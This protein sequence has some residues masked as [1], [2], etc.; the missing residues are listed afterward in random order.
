[1]RAQPWVVAASCLVSCLALGQQTITDGTFNNTDWTVTTISANAFS[2]TAT[3]SQAPSG[4]NPGFYRTESHGGDASNITTP[5]P[6]RFFHAYGVQTLNLTNGIASINYG[7]DLFEPSGSGPVTPVE[8]RL[9]LKQGNNIYVGPA[10]SAAVGQNPWNSFFRTGITATG[11]CLVAASTGA[12]DCNSHPNFAAGAASIQVGYQVANTIPAF[13]R[14]FLTSGIDNF[15]ITAISNAPLNCTAT[16]TPRTIRL[17]GITELAGDVILICTGGAPTASSPIPQVNIFLTTNANV[18]ITTAAIGSTLQPNQRIGSLLLLDELPPQINGPGSQ[19]FP[20]D[21]ASGVCIGYGNGSGAN[22]YGSGAQSAAAPNNRTIHA[23]FASGP[24]SI[25]WQFPLDAPAA[26][27]QRIIRLTN[28]RVDTRALQP[29]SNITATITIVPLVGNQNPLTVNVTGQPI[30]ATT[31]APLATTLRDA[32]N[33]TN[34]AAGNGVLFPLAQLNSFQRAGTFRYGEGFAT[35]F[36]AR[37]ATPAVDVNTSPIPVAQSDLTKPPAPSE[38]G[39]Y[40]PSFINP[41]TVGSYSA[42]GLATQGTRLVARFS[43]LQP[44]TSIYVDLTNIGANVNGDAARLTANETGPFSAVAGGGSGVPANVAQLAVSDTGTATA[45]WEVLAADPNATTNF[46]F[47]FYYSSTAIPLPQNSYPAPQVDLAIAPADSTSIPRFS[48]VASPRTLFSFVNPMVCSAA[49]NP[50]TLRQNGAAEL[51]SDIVLTCTGGTPTAPGG[52]IPQTTF[53]LTSTA[54]ITTP[55]NTGFVTPASN[56]WAPAGAWAILD[57]P[58]ANSEFPCLLRFSCL[59]FGNGTGQGYY[60]NGAQ[61]SETPNVRNFYP[62]SYP[63]LQSTTVQAPTRSIVWESVPVDGIG[64]GLRVFRFTGVR[65]STLNADSSAILGTITSTSANIPVVITNGA[66]LALG[67]ISNFVATSLRTADNS[68][69]LPAQGATVP[70]IPL[71]AFQQISVLRFRKLYATGFLPRIVGAPVSLDA[72]P[73]V[74]L[75]SQ[76]TVGTVF[77]SETGFWNPAFPNN[78]TNGLGNGGLAGLADQGTR[79]VARFANLPPGLLLYVD[80]YNGGAAI[81]GRAARL[82]PVEAGPFAAAP[83]TTGLPQSNVAQITVNTDGTATAVWEVLSADTL[84]A[85]S[86][87]DFGVYAATGAALGG[88]LPPNPTVRLSVGPNSTDQLPSPVYM[89]RF[90]V[91]S[92]ASNLITFTNPPPVVPTPPP[93]PALIVNPTQLSFTAIAGAPSP[94]AQALSLTSSFAGVSFNFST[95]SGGQLPITVT[96]GNGV[97]PGSATVSVN[98]VGLAPGTYRDVVTIN[99]GGTSNGSVAVGIIVTVRSAPVITSLDPRSTPAGSGPINLSVIGR[100]FLPGASVNF[101]DASLTP[102]FITGGQLNVSVPSNLLTQARVVPVTVTNPDGAVSN[103]ADFVVS[104]FQIL[105]L[106]PDRRTATAQGFNLTVTGNGFLPGA[107]VRF[108]DNPLTPASGPGFDTTSLTVSVPASAIATA[109]TVQVSVSNPTGQVSNTLPFTVRPVPVIDSVNPSSIP[110]GAPATTITIIGRNFFDG[111]TINWNGQPVPTTFGGA[112][113]LTAVVP[114]SLLTQPGGAALTAL[115]P[116]GVRSGP[117]TLPVGSFTINIPNLNVGDGNVSITITGPGLGPNTQ[118]QFSCPPAA[119]VTLQTTTG[120][121]N[122]ITVIIPGSLLTQPCAGQIIITGRSGTSTVPV[123]VLPAPQISGLSQTTAQAGGAAFTITVNGVGFEGGSAIR[124][125]NSLL[126]TGFV[127][128]TSLQGSVPAAL[129]ANPGAVN[130]TVVGPRGS[131]SNVVSFSVA[132]PALTGVGVTVP[133][134]SPSNTDQSGTVNFGAAFP[135]DLNGT[136][137]LTFRGDGGLPD[138]PAIQFSNGSRTLAFNVPANT[139][140]TVNFTLKAGTLAGVITITPQFTSGGAA[141]TATGLTPVTITIARTAPVLTAVSCTRGAGSF[142][143]VSDGFTNTRQATQAVFTFTGDNLTT[144][145]LTVDATA[146]FTAFAGGATTGGTFRYTQ[147]FNV[148][149]NANAV[150]SVAVKI[151]NSAGQSAER[152]GTCQ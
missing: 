63:L 92:T 142:N 34:I 113:Q 110:V 141:V 67:N 41:P 140:P 43:N 45:V 147:T 18:P 151:T 29:G 146:P 114:A 40:D 20:C 99:A 94:A 145:S 108:G 62:A 16:A 6:I 137:V 64:N 52:A 143:V 9:A 129:L 66:R 79:L 96:P 86:D 126:V 19:K 139:R 15:S 25:N 75:S 21:D 48:T 91:P 71:T 117:F 59:S 83:A 81:N 121:N 131:T 134:T 49:T 84:S 57:E 12:I 88:V 36:L 2:V 61:N 104:Q 149:G 4:G 100:G 22:Y 68:A 107:T 53:Q 111:V 144:S 89:P 122:S 24:N 3:G 82:T 39:F 101:G 1:M 109:G 116:D 102:V 148:Q 136:M 74:A 90:A 133:A 58:A 10:D 54:F 23:A 8:Y 105:S 72:P 11:F 14:L 87:F 80:I 152:S 120:T 112:T 27:Q 127:N 98:T 17:Q 119:P 47:G 97:V 125:G 30:I 130:I 35:A 56:P 124:W 13:Q 7:Y 70:F 93:A 76:A 95:S 135:A 28:V 42:A 50:R 46:D 123:P 44:G 132:L 51:V 115:T 60:G 128:G 37:S 150:Q 77:A 32:G 69:V 138:D 118:V 38:T 78:V 85:V 55:V 5:V 103:S 33:T 31:A 73:S 65:V 106:N 26:N